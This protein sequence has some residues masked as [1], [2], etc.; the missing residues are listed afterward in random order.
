MPRAWLTRRVNEA[1][2]LEEFL[3]LLFLIDAPADL[4]KTIRLNGKRVAGTCEWILSRN[5]YDRW[6]G[7][8]ALQILWL[9]GAPGIGKTA[10]ACFLIEH[11]EKPDASQPS[12]ILIHH[13]CDYKD[14]GPRNSALGIIRCI[15]HQLLK[16]QPHLFQWIKTEYQHRHERSSLVDNLDG[17]WAV[18]LKLIQ[19]CD[20]KNIYIIIDALDECDEASRITLSS[21][22]AEIPVS[23]NVK[24]LITARSD[25]DIEGAAEIVGGHLRVDSG[26][27]KT[28]LAA[29]IDSRLAELKEK[30]KT[31]PESLIDEIGHKVK[32]HAGGTFLWVS[33][34]FKDMFA[35]RTSKAAAK[36]LK[37][38]P[39]NLP[40]IYKRI[41]DTI[42]DENVEDAAFILRWTVLSK[43]PMNVTEM[44][45]AQVLAHEGWQMDTVPPAE[46]LEQFKDG[47]KACGH[48]L[49]YDPVNDTLN[50]IHR[51]AKDFLV[52]A[53]CPPKYR[54]NSE[55]AGID[56]IGTCWQ[57]LSMRDF[58][59]GASFLLRDHGNTLIPHGLHHIYQRRYGFF[60]F[61]FDEVRDLRGEYRLSLCAAFVQS[62]RTINDMPLLRDFWLFHFAKAGHVA[63]VQALISKHADVNVRCRIISYDLD[64][65]QLL[66]P[67]YVKVWSHYSWGSKLPPPTLTVLQGAAARG[68]VEVCRVLIERGAEVDAID[69]ADGE[70]ALHLAARF[71]HQD[72]VC[73]LLNKGALIDKLD[74]Q[75]R[76]PLSRALYAG[77]DKI[78]VLLLAR[79][80]NA[81]LKIPI[82]QRNAEFSISIAND[83]DFLS[84]QRKRDNGQPE[85]CS[86]VQHREG[87]LSLPVICLKKAWM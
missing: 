3:A 26:Q 43:R 65:T 4:A 48:L 1:N 47:F 44:A 74:N 25:V 14:D 72:V 28:D 66:L 57:Y 53:D 56:V 19:K 12:V 55:A 45:T 37:D 10:I 39:S 86:L 49:Y 29:F 68:H 84:G 34:V 27:I 32:S 13:F 22:I 24:I 60:N 73:L 87:E 70:S 8:N 38:L 30:K 40:G 17:L 46:Y 41:L 80:A 85:L 78:G 9:F 58:C 15:L 6:R 23:V 83:N 76:S 67:Q 51:T 31:F 69:E 35:T 21:L 75:G 59:Q 16:K 82:L 11:L 54:V 5:E 20:G 79:G 62:C 50:L 77:W 7:E 63:G 18:F 36:K 33:L 61:A 2:D 64:A 71:G 81:F 42:D 52:E